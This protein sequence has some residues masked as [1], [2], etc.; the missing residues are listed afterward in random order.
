MC[1]L[2]QINCLDAHLERL[3]ALLDTRVLRRV[4]RELWNALAGVLLL[5]F[6]HFMGCVSPPVGASCLLHFDMASKLVWLVAL[7]V[8][9]EDLNDCQED[10]S[11]GLHHS[12]G[13]V[14]PRIQHVDAALKVRPAGE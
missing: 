10:Q 5:S 3:A 7:Q 12:L 13:N 4:A 11:G 14:G 8:L 2:L 9:H 1:A 6:W